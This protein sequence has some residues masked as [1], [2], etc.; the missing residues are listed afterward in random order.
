MIV[1]ESID[2]IINPQEINATAVIAVSSAAILINGLT[3]WLLMKGQGD[4]INIKA[5]YLHAA[6]D[7]LV[8]VS[9]VISGIIISTTGW[10][11]MDPLL[12]LAVS[13]FIALP[14]I[15]L[16]LTTLKTIINR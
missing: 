6:T 13:I 7:A 8:S 15:K 4:D 3:A 10:V 12:S 14:T 1:Y 2:K 16:I 11:L 5:A 9:V